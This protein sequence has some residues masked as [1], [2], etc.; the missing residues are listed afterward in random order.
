MKKSVYG[1]NRI[2]CVGS[3]SQNRA[4]RVSPGP[5]EEISDAESYYKEI[6]EKYVPEE[7][8]HLLFRYLYRNRAEQIFSDISQAETEFLSDHGGE[9]RWMRCE[10]DVTTRT[11]DGAPDGY[12]LCV[13]DIDALMR[14]HLEDQKKEKERE[15]MEKHAFENSNIM[16]FTYYVTEGYGIASAGIEDLHGAPR[17]LEGMPDSFRDQFVDPD[18]YA[19]H[20]EMYRRCMSGINHASSEL[21]DVNGH[22]TR[23]TLEIIDTDSDGRPAAILGIVENTDELHR[24]RDEAELMEEV[25]R[26]AVE[27]H[28]EEADL[29]DLAADTVRSVLRNPGRKGGSLCPGETESYDGRIR[30]LISERAAGEEDAA[31][32][33]KLYLGNLPG[34][35]EKN[36]KLSLRVR[37]RSEDGEIRWKLLEGIF[38]GDDHRRIIMLCTDIQGEE[39]IREQLRS[40]AADAQEAN[41]AKSAFLANMS[42][43]IRTPMNSIVGISEILLGKPLPEDVLMDISTIQNSGSSLLGIINDILDFSKIETGKLEINETDYMLPSLLMDVSNVISV[44]IS[45]RP[46]F[47]MMDIDPAI[48]SRLYGD[49]IRLKQI[50]LNL[51]GNSAKFTREGYIELRVEGRMTDETHCE[52][53]FEI[54]DSGIGI[55][56]E[57]F[58]KLFTTFSQVDTKRNREISGSGLG[59]AISRNLARMMGGDLTVESEYGK[60]SL[61]TVRIVQTVKE[62]VRFGEVKDPGKYRILIC[63][64][65]EAVIHSLTRTMEKLGLDYAVC[66]ETDRLRSYEGMTHVL[67]RRKSFLDLREKLEFMF[68]KENICLI[69]D[70]GEHAES[71]FLQYKQLQLPLICMQ[72]INVL[73][74]EEIV[75]SIKKKSFDRSQI[76]PLSF[77]RILIVDDNTTNLQVAQGLMA[78]YRMKIDVAAS[79]FKAIEMVKAVRYDAIF[80]DHMMPEMDGIE[81]TQYI[82]KLPGDYY[83]KVPIIALTANAM[84]DARAMFLSSG[85]DDFVAKP[86]EMA[87]LNRVLKKYVL[88]KAP[89]GY[90]EKMAERIGR[91]HAR[92]GQAPGADAPGRAFPRNAG[93]ADAGTDGSM[94]SR[95]LS[96]NNLVLRQNLLLLQAL[97]GSA[98]PEADTA[99]ENGPERN[100]VLP[101]EIPAEA[102]AADHGAAE[103]GAEAEPAGED[104]AGEG[105]GGGLDELRAPIPGIHMRESVDTYGGSVRIYHNI[106][107]TY[108][109]DLLE[110]LPKLDEAVGQGD[111]EAF[112]ICVHAVRSASLSVG[113]SDVGKMAEELEEAGRRRDG[114]AVGSLYPEF[115]ENLLRVMEGTG[116]YVRRYLEK[117]ADSGEEAE[118]AFPPDEV[119]AVRKACR[120]MDYMAVER[121]LERLGTRRYTKELEEKLQAMQ[122]LAEGFEYDLLDELVESL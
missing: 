56:R 70:S 37:L 61:F 22:W 58:G 40:A 30:S 119:E 48:P 89:E 114:D 60:G 36:G 83:R 86:I 102:G 110:R 28:Y 100:G 66:R 46:I 35:I 5:E 41:R 92:A 57:D 51:I 80:M 116:K 13:K 98:G 122:R 97:L 31:A 111:L 8:R 4:L 120:D 90:R 99:G 17:R 117:P 112:T 9:R 18:F 67:I 62:Y 71:H 55:R 84:S 94:M 85:M 105:A 53:V 23:V 43:E 24:A 59:L 25:C 75:T 32:L 50:L 34:E 49:D 15:L 103:A 101:R 1:I 121:L 3:F 19:F 78:P 69:L 63:E 74:G 73:N 64:Q 82:R 10:I 12:C 44:R 104:P 7:Q 33:E 106:L 14:R 115:R 113:A 118:A 76:V 109:Y 20:D 65:N 42:H 79:G 95:L 52:L 54:K 2:I 108:Y 38:F 29:I 93:A 6:I 21:R 47:F 88:P 87:E 107:K 81:T 77:A 91:E 72:I 39:D 68:P 27:N 16:K 96:Q 11:E 26:F 45:G